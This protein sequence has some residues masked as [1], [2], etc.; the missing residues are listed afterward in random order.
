M[1]DRHRWT[2]ARRSRVEPPS[3]GALAAERRTGWGRGCGAIMR[4]PPPP[5]HPQRPPPFIPPSRSLY[6]FVVNSA[7]GG[8]IE[9]RFWC[10][11]FAA[12]G[13][14]ATMCVGAQRTGAQQRI[15][16]APA[17]QCR[18]APPALSS[19]VRPTTHHH[20]TQL[21]RGGA[22]LS[23][24]SCAG[25][26]GRCVWRASAQVLCWK[27]AASSNPNPAQS[28]GLRSAV[29]GFFTS[30]ILVWVVRQM[31]LS[32]RWPSPHE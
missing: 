27:I 18:G 7:I 12:L 32:A 29:F 25:K 4:C 17:L 28:A 5:R 3:A 31:P 6:G 15:G 1:F 21:G 13:A 2:L 19:A 22:V 20:H 24:S 10:C 8:H 30:K 14:G 16:R 9:I 23:H 26:G 11:A